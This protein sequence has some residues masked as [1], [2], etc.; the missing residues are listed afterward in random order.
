MFELIRFIVH[1]GLHFIF[2]YF[3]ARRFRA[4]RVWSTYGILLST[5]LVDLDHILANPIFDPCRCS[6]GFHPLHSFWA[7]LL[8]TI[9]LAPKITRWWS[10]G[11]L[12][13]MLTDLQDCWWGC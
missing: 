12:L 8:Y 2:P 3:V 6:I 5:M 1:Y 9:L 4:D 11:L 13:H 10:I 7:I